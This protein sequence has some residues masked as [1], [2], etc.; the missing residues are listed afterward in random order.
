[1]T[2]ITI[3]VQRKRKRWSLTNS[4]CVEVHFLFL[5]DIGTTFKDGAGVILQISPLVKN[6]HVK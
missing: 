1:M 6:L 5:K 2:T 3:T 4:F